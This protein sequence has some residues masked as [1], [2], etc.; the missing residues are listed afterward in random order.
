M[1]DSVV[2]SDFKNTLQQSPFW[3]SG[4][5]IL[6]GVTAQ[7]RTFDVEAWQGISIHGPLG[8]SC[9]GLKAHEYSILIASG[10]FEAIAKNLLIN[11]ES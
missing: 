8:L 6:Y 10:N 7:R 5:A 9:I 1:V 11:T 4:H 2:A 3:G